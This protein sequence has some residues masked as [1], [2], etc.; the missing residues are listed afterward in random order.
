MMAAPAAQPM[1]PPVTSAGALKARDELEVKL[2][3][4][5]GRDDI[6]NGAFDLCCLSGEFVRS[7]DFFETA[8][9]DSPSVVDV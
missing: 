3:R 8:T 9:A 4:I 5:D 1:R 2:R 6:A 7:F